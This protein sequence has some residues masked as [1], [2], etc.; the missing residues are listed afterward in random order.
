M[1]GACERSSRRQLRS[2]SRQFSISSASRSEIWRS[3]Q[4][5]QWLLCQERWLMDRRRVIAAA[6][7]RSSTQ[8][9]AA[10]EELLTNTLT[11]SELITPQEVRTALNTVAE[12]GRH[13]V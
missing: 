4:R 9:W 2:D 5:T 8:A 3:L 1:R 6:P 11:S 10:I 13:L 7:F 12:V